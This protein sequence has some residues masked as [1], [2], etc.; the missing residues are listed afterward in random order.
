MFF[1][2]FSVVTYLVEIVWKLVYLLLPVPEYLSDYALLEL[3]AFFYAQ[4]FSILF[5]IPDDHDCGFYFLFL[6][7]L[8]VVGSIHQR[9]A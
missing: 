7:I 3:L 9:W 5:N 6:I 4:L 2:L 1:G 8:L